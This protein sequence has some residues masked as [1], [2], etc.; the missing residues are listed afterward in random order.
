MYV[1]FRRIYQ[2]PML[3]FEWLIF[4]IEIID[5]MGTRTL[6]HH[7]FSLDGT[8]VETKFLARLFLMS[9]LSVVVSVILSV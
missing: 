6:H 2:V 5:E 3:M 8:R 9:N 7:Q 1:Y 4:Q